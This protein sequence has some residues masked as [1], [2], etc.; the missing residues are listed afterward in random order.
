MATS[1]CWQSTSQSSMCLWVFNH[2]MM[3]NWTRGVERGVGQADISGTGVRNNLRGQRQDP[4]SPGSRGSAILYSPELHYVSCIQCL[5]HPLG[6]F[7]VVLIT[8]CQ[9][10][11][12]TQTHKQTDTQK[13]TDTLSYMDNTFQQLLH[14]YTQYVNYVYYSIFCILYSIYKC[15]ILFY[16]LYIMSFFILFFIYLF[17]QAIIQSLFQWTIHTT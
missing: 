9:E 13:F 10:H 15:C 7:A 12:L 4:G 2:D 3:A 14:N 16:I 11:S 5:S 6:T 8:H 1:P 17:F